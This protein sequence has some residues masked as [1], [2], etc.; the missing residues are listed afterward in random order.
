MTTLLAFVSGCFLGGAFIACRLA[1]FVH[2][3]LKAAV[4]AREEALQFLKNAQA[5]VEQGEMI[6]K[7]LKAA[8]EK[9]ERVIGPDIPIVPATNPVDKGRSKPK[10]SPDFKPM[11]EQEFRRALG[12]E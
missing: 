4:K 2:A 1:G 6:A 5:H 11:N 10:D 8:Q 12:G 7:E 9:V 3:N